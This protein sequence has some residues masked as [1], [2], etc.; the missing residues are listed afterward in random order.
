MSLVS[1]RVRRVK[2]VAGGAESGEECGSRDEK[3]HRSQRPSSLY[4]IE[5][6]AFAWILPKAAELSIS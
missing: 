2:D 6:D 1:E 4:G 5:F 3:T